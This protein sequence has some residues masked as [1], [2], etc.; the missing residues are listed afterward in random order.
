MKHWFLILIASLLSA[1]GNSGTSTALGTLERDRMTLTS[2]A[3][4]VIDSILVQEGDQVEKGQLL[5][6]FDDT[7]AKAHVTSALAQLEQAK[8]KLSELKTGV[9][10]ETI[11][12]VEAQVRGA[13]SAWA[14][15]D[16]QFNRTKSLLRQNLTGEAEMDGA[17]ARR[18]TAK[19][20]Y[21]QLL[22]QLNELKNGTR[23]E[24]IEQAVQSVTMAKANVTIAEKNLENLSLRAPQNAMIDALPWHV[25]DRVAAGITT[26]TLLA[27]NQPY[28][29]VYLPAN[30]LK[31]IAT[32]DTLAVNIDGLQ[33]PVLGNL[34]HVRAQ[35]SFTPYFSLSE[36]DRDALMYL[37][38]IHFE[39]KYANMIVNVPSGR[40]L[41]VVLP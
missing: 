41:E 29:R 9:R 34:A 23:P 3:N 33:T 31:S 18:D 14:E 12:Q 4:E 7:T 40:A 17:K 28:A 26:I 37:S 27:T 5:L 21:Q 39:G 10:S 35:P 1:C 13:K 2:P 30:K 6:T 36:Q 11:S 25:G 8:A 22:E 38:E 16:Q 24:Q 15:A 32:G 20:H 19:A